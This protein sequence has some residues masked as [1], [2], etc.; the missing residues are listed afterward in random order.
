MV[1]FDTDI[2]V[3]LEIHVQ[4]D[5][6][7]KLFCGCP[8][9]GSDVPNSRCCPV[10]LG[11]PGSKPVLNRQ[12]VMF[13]L[14][15]ALA[16]DCEIAKELIFSRKSYFYPDMAKNYQ[17]TQYEI[18]LGLGGEIALASGKK[19]RLKRIHME[20]DPAAL[21]HPAG[22]HSSSYVLVDYNRSGN[23]LCEVVTEPDIASSDEARDFM[24]Q[25]ISILEYLEI[26]D[27]R[28]GIIKADVNVSVRES[29]Y[30]RVEVKNI[31]G[32]REI[33]KAIEYEI[34]R[35]K[36]AVKEGQ[37]IE[38]ET[39][40]WD[41]DSE[42]TRSLR[43]KESEDDYAYIL[44][45][46]LTKTVL[47]EELIN[48]VRAGIPELAHEK[49]KRFASEFS[50]PKEDAEILA[51]EMRL[52]EIFEKVARKVDPNLAAKWLRRE[53]VRVMNYNELDFVDLKVDESHVSQ[54]LELV[55][56]K[57]ITENVARKILEK[58][59]IEP[60]DV[61]EYVDRN[62]LAIVSDSSSLEQYAKEAIS[63]NPDA[64]GDYL[65]GKEK[66]INF[67]MGQV[68]RKSRGT[69][70]AKEVLDILKKL[71]VK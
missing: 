56:K 52:S 7:T 30:T 60:F 32:F 44:D 6:K 20:E 40:S 18:P 69:A 47:S 59:I 33:E 4:L 1:E 14:K 27:L 11:H 54:L 36:K 67:L 15:L 5:T 61:R 16:A 19:I 3:G 39:R 70:S 49:S 28:N 22:M 25:L 8:T 12:A 26:F 21:V 24:K 41:S 57:Q 64:V 37:K 42:A 29:E 65:A 17:I 55:E 66:S 13:A 31:T 10:C 62:N 9:H 2:V 43:T 48:E 63:E 34:A 71:I 51:A 35:Q 23:P 68:M 53:F 50:I 45:P 58:L 38:I 46:D